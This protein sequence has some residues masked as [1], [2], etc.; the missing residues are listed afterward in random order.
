MH[1]QVDLE[2][3]SDLVEIK[4]DLVADVACSDQKQER[5]DFLLSTDLDE[6]SRSRSCFQQWGTNIRAVFM[7][8]PLMTTKKKWNS[9]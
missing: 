6:L 4:A 1:T 9:Y 5:I 3:P 2:N 7:L 8:S